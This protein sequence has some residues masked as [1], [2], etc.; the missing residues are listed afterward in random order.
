MNLMTEFWIIR[1]IAYRE[2]GSQSKGTRNSSTSGSSMNLIAF[3]SDSTVSSAIGIG[4]GPT[5]RAWILSPQ[6]N[7]SPKNG[8]T[9]V[10]H[11]YKYKE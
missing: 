8:T 10:G 4:A 7:W 1:M 2:T 11:C 3:E 9:V 6:K 5:L